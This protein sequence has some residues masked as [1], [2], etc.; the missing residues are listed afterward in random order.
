MLEV[1]C[2]VGCVLQWVCA[3]ALI[4]GC[5]TPIVRHPVPINLQNE[6]HV[7]G[8]P[9]GIRAWGDRFSPAFQRSIGE[10]VRQAEAA[11]GAN[12]PTDILALSGGGSYGAFGA[13]LLCGWTDAGNRPTFRIVTGISTG[14][15]IAPFAFLG[16]KYDPQLKQ[17]STQITSKDI[18]RPKALLVAVGSDSF[19]LTTPLTNLLKRY[20]DETVLRAIAAEHAKGRRLYIGTTNLDAQRAVIWDMGAIA[21][22][23]SPRAAEIFREVILASSAIPAYFPPVYV[24]VDAGGKHYDEMHVD[25]GA[26]D[27]VILYGDAASLQ[28][29]L[30]GVDPNGPAT[31]PSVYVIRNG[32]VGPEPQAVKPHV[33]EIAEAALA[34]LTKSEALG[35]LYRIY[36]A[37]RRDGFDFKLSAIPDDY[38]F[39]S[40]DTLDAF[41]PKVMKGLFDRGYLLGRSGYRWRDTPPGLN[42]TTQPALTH[43][44]ASSH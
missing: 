20:Y 19:T 18:F 10:S 16:S 4:Q 14:A 5:G 23:K 42:S 12:P 21:S 24:K 33:L 3:M 41:D 9:D 40:T 36:V 27:Q 44:P 28:T 8:M 1:V 11:Y 34:S 29:M 39:P 25:G 15:V 17:L 30:H 35:D 6:A 26:T 7:S 2:S 31:L 22:S 37:A 32:K 13:G 43:E 38:Q